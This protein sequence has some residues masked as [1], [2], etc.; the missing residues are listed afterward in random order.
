MSI[1]LD[2]IVPV[3]AYPAGFAVLSVL[4]CLLFLAWGWRRTGLTL[5][6]C[7]TLY[8]WLAATPVV[9]AFLASSLERQ[10]PVVPMQNLPAADV[11]VVLGG[12]INAPTSANPNPDMKESID[13][14]IHAARLFRA[15]LAPRII[16]SGG[17]LFP[18][19]DRAP[20]A[21]Y[22]AQMLGQLGVGEASI[23]QEGSARNT[24]ENGVLTARLMAD[25]SL[26]TAL[27]VTSAWHMPRAAAVFRRAGVRFT[28]VATDT[29]SSSIDTGF[30]FGYLPSAEALM[31]STLCLKEWIGLAVYRLRGWV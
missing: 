3:F 22:A 2:K 9:A 26:E 31:Q 18:H 27:L 23:L 17:Q 15:G 1:L 4:A 13:R 7:G 20:E 8:M 16:A 29:L 12:S 30:P 10:Y 6:V 24:Y 25:N 19:P 5:L 14:V 28:P 11:I 21:E